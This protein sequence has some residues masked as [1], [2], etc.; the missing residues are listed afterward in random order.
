MG[1]TALIAGVICIYL[2]I[3]AQE[4]LMTRERRIR[5]RLEP[6]PG[7]GRAFVRGYFTGLAIYALGGAGLLLIA[8]GIA[9]LA[10]A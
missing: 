5:R 9:Q 4:G 3:R 2:A 7:F 10:G 8:L 1:V 6:V